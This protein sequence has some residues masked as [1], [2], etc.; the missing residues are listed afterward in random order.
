MR[1]MQKK[2][3]TKQKTLKML[4]YLRPSLENGLGDSIHILEQ[5]V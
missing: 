3:K 4:T 5:S 1:S 2:N